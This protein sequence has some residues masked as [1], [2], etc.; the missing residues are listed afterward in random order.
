M[1][2]AVETKVHAIDLGEP[3]GVA[4]R[5]FCASARNP[6]ARETLARASG[7]FAMRGGRHVTVRW[8]KRNLR[9]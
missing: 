5:I 8:T 1:R 4:W 7:D 2:S 6:I 3:F 9:G